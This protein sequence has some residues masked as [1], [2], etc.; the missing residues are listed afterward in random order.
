MAQH[1]RGGTH[2][3]GALLG[4]GGAVDGAPIEFVNPF[5]RYKTLVNNFTTGADSE[6]ADFATPDPTTT[7][8]RT[9]INGSATASATPVAP[10]TQ[11]SYRGE[12]A[13][14][15]VGSTVNNQGSLWVQGRFTG[16]GWDGATQFVRPEVKR[17]WWYAEANHVNA[18]VRG[19]FAIGVMSDNTPPLTNAGALAAAPSMYGFYLDNAEVLHAV[20]GSA[21]NTTLGAVT[22]QVPIRMAVVCTSRGVT[23]AGV[24]L[25]GSQIDFYLNGKLVLSYDPS[26]LSIRD[27]PI[28]TPGICVVRLTNTYAA[29]VSHWAMATKVV[30]T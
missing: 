21:V 18:A 13:T 25:P 24:Y 22:F 28:Q 6:A 9:A 2:T 8:W 11:A 26:T 12:G 7:L 23:A 5:H 1:I 30:S 19:A 4:R 3:R 29:R 27:E 15:F 14:D 10:T 17:V 20:H 16:S